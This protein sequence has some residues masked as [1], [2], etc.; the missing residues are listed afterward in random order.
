MASNPDDGKY[1]RN[2][3]YD[4][5]GEFS[6]QDYF[7]DN[8]ELFALL[9]V[10]GGISVYFAQMPSD[11]ATEATNF[12]NRAINM[13]FLSGFILFLLVAKKLHE[14]LWVDLKNIPSQVFLLFD[15][16]NYELLLFI[17]S[18]YSLLSSVIILLSYNINI[19]LLLEGLAF[20]GPIYIIQKIYSK[21]YRYFHTSFKWKALSLIVNFIIIYSSLVVLIYSSSDYRDPIP[22]EIQGAIVIILIFQ[23]ILTIVGTDLLIMLDYYINIDYILELLDR[24]TKNS[25]SKVPFIQP[26]IVLLLSITSVYI[27]LFPLFYYILHQVSVPLWFFYVLHSSLLNYIPQRFYIVEGIHFLSIITHMISIM[28]AIISSVGCFFFSVVAHPRRSLTPNQ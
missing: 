4:E 5:L 12:H 18:F 20:I 21:V 22:D 2:Y 17:I 25:A 13:G 26:L 28:V 19:P 9:G 1:I 16:R 3:S 24:I 6:L 27:Y 23:T 15:V 11:F 7:E 8:Y 10:F 14:G